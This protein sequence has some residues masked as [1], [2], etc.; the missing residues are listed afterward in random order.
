MSKKGVYIQVDEA[1]TLWAPGDIMENRPALS[2]W[3]P[4]FTDLFEQWQIR[5]TGS[6]Q[7]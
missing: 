7:P 3:H 5:S 6:L 2:R 1:I 4:D